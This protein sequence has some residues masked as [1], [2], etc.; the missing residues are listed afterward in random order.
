[1]PV[2]GY[3]FPVLEKCRSKLRNKKDTNGPRPRVK[4]RAGL[5]RRQQ[6]LQSSDAKGMLTAPHKSKRTT[7]TMHKSIPTFKMMPR[8]AIRQM[9][10]DWE[11]YLRR[12]CLFP[13]VIPWNK[14]PVTTVNGKPRCGVRQEY[15]SAMF[16]HKL[17]GLLSIAGM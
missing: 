5:P 3:H 11:H 8:V 15:K 13:Q 7:T 16:A 6:H 2:R 17:V 14:S 12:V 1:M 9:L 4:A 10:K